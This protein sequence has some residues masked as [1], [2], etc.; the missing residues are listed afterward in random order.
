[1]NPRLCPSEAPF[2]GSFGG[3]GSRGGGASPADTHLP[4]SAPADSAPA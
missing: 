4:L 3:L 1:M 2:Y